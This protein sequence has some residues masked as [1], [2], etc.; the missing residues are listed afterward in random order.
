MDPE[1]LPTVP[2]HGR[3]VYDPSNLPPDELTYLNGRG[4]DGDQDDRVQIM[5][6]DPIQNAEKRRLMDLLESKHRDMPWDEEPVQPPPKVVKGRG[7]RA[8]KAR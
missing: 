5:Y 3:F 7:G 8:K 6:E 4:S 2:R 1:V